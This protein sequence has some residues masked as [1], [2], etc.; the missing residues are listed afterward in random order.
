MG[1]GVGGWVLGGGGWELGGLG[2]WGLGLER[3]PTSNIKK[4]H[5]AR[6]H[7]PP[8]ASNSFCPAQTFQRGW[9][10]GSVGSGLGGVGGVK[11]WDHTLKNSGYCT[12][13]CNQLK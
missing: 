12:W 13:M 1:L 6:I 11:A 4:T 8:E 7:S 2:A 9:G 10:G 3:L 5:H